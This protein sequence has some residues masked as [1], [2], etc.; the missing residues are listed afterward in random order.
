MSNGVERCKA[1]NDSF[2]RPDVD[3][4]DA[5]HDSGHS[6]CAYC[7]TDLH[8]REASFENSTDGA[9]WSE[10]GQVRGFGGRACQVP[11]RRGAPIK[12]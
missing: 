10:R 11:L 4:E 2:R 6:V 1:C 9:Q 5:G 7:A 3:D 8:Y 12:A